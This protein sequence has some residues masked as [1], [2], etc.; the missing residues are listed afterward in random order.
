MASGVHEELRAHPVPGVGRAAR[1][2]PLEYADLLAQMRL[3][4][5][6]PMEPPIPEAF[7]PDDAL[8]IKLAAKLHSQPRRRA[9][10]PAAAPQ[11]R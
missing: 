9:P 1:P 2:A 5:G 3:D 4:C 10:K 7:F 6:R 11:P 8:L